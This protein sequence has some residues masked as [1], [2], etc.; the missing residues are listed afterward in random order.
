M[1]HEVAPASRIEEDLPTNRGIA[2]IVGKRASQA[3]GRDVVD[4][5]FGRDAAAGDGIRT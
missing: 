3:T 5:V 2:A 1:R 4:G